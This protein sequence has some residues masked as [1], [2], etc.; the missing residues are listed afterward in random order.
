MFS[1]LVFLISSLV[2]FISYKAN[3]RLLEELQIS[4]LQ[5]TVQAVEREF[6]IVFEAIANDVLF[7]SDIPTIKYLAEYHTDF[8]LDPPTP[9]T[10]QELINCSKGTFL[11]FMRNRDNYL[12]VRFIGSTEQQREVIRIENCPIEKRLKIFQNQILE[13]TDKD[14]YFY[15][16]FNLDE[17]QLYL[18]PINLHREHGNIIKP[19]QPTVRVATPIYS[20]TY[21]SAGVLIIQVS[22]QKLLDKIQQRLPEHGLLYIAN[23]QGDYLLH[24]DNSKAFAFEFAQTAR[25]QDEFPFTQ[26]LIDGTIK[27]LKKT[28]LQLSADPDQKKYFAYFSTAYLNAQK[29]PERRV[30]IGFLQLH[31]TISSSRQQVLIDSVR[32]ALVLCLMGMGITFLFAIYLT[33]PLK[34]ITKAVQHFSHGARDMHLSLSQHDEIGEL[35][36]TCQKMADKIHWQMLRLGD[37]KN[38]LETIFDTAVEGI[39]VTNEKGVVE[40]VNHAMIGLFGYPEDEL[41]GNNINMLMPEELRRRHDLAIQHYISTG[42]AEVVGAGREVLGLRKDGHVLHLH[43]GVSELWVVHERKF[44]GMMHDISARKKAEQTILEARDRAETAN[45]AKS[46]FL[47]NMSHEFRT[48]LNGILGY[49]QLLRRDNQLLPKHREYVN[50]IHRSGE[51]L[52]ALINDILDLSKIEAGRL[53]VLP[54][55]LDFP[56]LV[57]DIG[58]LFKARAEQK[59]IKFICETV[60]PLPA[61]IYADGKRLRQV[62]LNILG[63]AVKFTQRGSVTFRVGVHSGVQCFDII[64]TGI[65]IPDQA[66]DSIFKPFHQVEAQNQHIEGT[67]LGLTITRRLVEMMNG[68]IVV[69]SQEG[70]GSHF[71][72]EFRFPILKNPNVAILNKAEQRPIV[73]CKDCQHYELLCV[74]DKQDNRDLL[75][76]LLLPLGFKIRQA[77][78]GKVAL[79]KLQQSKIDLVLLDLFMPVMDGFSTAQAIRANPAWHDMPVIALSAGVFSQQKQQALA[80]GCNTFLEKPVKTDELLHLLQKYLHVEW[81]YAELEETSEVIRSASNAALLHEYLPILE[82]YARQGDIQAILDTINALPAGEADTEFFAQIKASAEDMD[83]HTLRRLLNQYAEA[84]QA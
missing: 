71:H 57:K 10:K 45:R 43:I 69:E 77:E 17:N 27:R 78:N 58:Y 12:Q 42:E 76:S 13:E 40:S 14:H 55:E 22:M 62:L 28:T 72:L 31:E 70:C 52:L 25:M 23:A 33:R 54:V 3:N 26:G 6:A 47:A 1:F 19:H 65:G 35:A 20:G 15:T 30:Q 46:H 38:Y 2:G 53:E 60:T 49:T 44:V 67:G 48:P 34:E 73:A 32:N 37:E 24:P 82:Q 7:L 36:R 50:V 83:L 79:E 18:S 8:L 61:G 74:D 59:G 5:R 21:E 75:A 84:L 64:D 16:A 80:A 41:L 66:Q 4:Q 81:E 63:N 56:D 9:L 68:H 51:H 29:F 39:V 11:G